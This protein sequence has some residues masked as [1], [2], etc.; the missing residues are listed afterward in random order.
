[1]D[2]KTLKT[3]EYPR[4]LSSL[5][6]QCHF[7]PARERALELHPSSDL[8]EVRGLQNET[9]DAV[10][11]LTLHPGT[12]IGGARDLR[13]IVEDAERGIIL[14]PTRLLQVKDSLVAART[15]KRQ[16]LRNQGEFPT[17][18]NISTYLPE[19]LGL[20]S[21]ISKVISEKN[22][23][24]DS[25]S[26]RLGQIRRDLKTQHTRLKNRMNQM[27]KKPEV[28]KFLQEAIVTQRNGR[29][30]LPLKAE[31]RTSVPGIVHDQSTSGATIYVEPQAMVE[32]NNK[33]RKLELDERDEVQRI[34]AEL[35]AKVA[36]QGQVLREMVETL[37]RLDLAFARGRYALRLNAFPPTLH[38]FP[39]KQKE[40]HPGV[41]LRLFGA[42]HPLLDPH[43]V[44][45]IDV[46]LDKDT[47]G[48]IITGPNTGGKTV[49]LKTVGLLVLMA[50]T[51]LH[52]PTSG[53]SEISLFNNVY[54]DIGD[55]QS[56]EQS[57]STFSG[58]I[59]NIIKIL[60]NV[61]RRSLVILDE[62]GAGTDPQ[63]GA[64]LARALMSNLLDRGITSLVT[65]HHPDLKA[66]AHSTP[67]VINASVEFDLKSLRPTYHLTIGLPGRSNALAI[68]GRLGLPD[69]I[70]QAAR[71][72]L[73]P[74]DLR[75]DDLLDE[76]HKQRKLAQAT[77]ESADKAHQ[78]VERLRVQ[79]ADRIVEI[80]DERLVI[81]GRIQLDYKDKLQSL[82]DELLSIKED[83][84][85]GEIS[86]E[87][88][89]ELEEMT[90]QVQEEISKPLPSKKTK[91]ELP[92][93][94]GPIQEGDKVYLRSLGKKGRVIA[95]NGNSVEIQVGNMRVR[96]QKSDLE[97][98]AAEEKAEV[99]AGHEAIVRT[100][101]EVTSPGTELDLRGQ[102]VDEA[103]E[104]LGYFLDKA[105]LARLPWARIIHG[106][107]TGRLRNAVRDVLGKHPQ[108]DHFEPGKEGE[109]GDGVSVV[110]FLE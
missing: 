34:L 17:L 20:V 93:P 48:L 71:G 94:V 32:A 78:E 108:V 1:M 57:L 13:P 64:A 5:A 86:E 6:D 72:T 73:D 101:T 15:L 38:P 14:E 25:A 55:E 83:L 92:I 90:E 52:I 104:N 99:E 46:V 47:Y 42:R 10:A 28:A 54:A 75:A 49:T 74:A 88:I 65:T 89:E 2:Q 35:T 107:G 87:K 67:G 66:Y 9:A 59:T 51:G 43:Q 109:G 39:K 8:E 81:L 4:I 110:S 80:E 79:L 69:E 56:I 19:S 85:K 21:L 45:A 105:F 44:V 68:A 29:Y 70:I 24:L 77:R 98:A 16:F 41:V 63:E 84:E 53:S 12:T 11:L 91:L 7:N 36:E 40:G 22:E 50:Q 26:E 96:A 103:L 95:V 23:V 82:Q 62:L 106:V 97:H 37:T 33:F 76:I 27:L 100:P 58:H 30:V 60:E 31:A 18:E 3:L 61:D 102:Q